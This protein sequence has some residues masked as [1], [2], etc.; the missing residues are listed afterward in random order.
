MRYA[1]VVLRWRSKADGE[2]LVVVI[3][4]QT[5]K[6]GAALHVCK[7]SSDGVHLSDFLF[8]QILKS[9]IDLVQFEA[10]DP[11]LIVSFV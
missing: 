7:R 11:H 3:V 10:H 6:S 5:E 4:L 1:R 9:M 2:D 8:P